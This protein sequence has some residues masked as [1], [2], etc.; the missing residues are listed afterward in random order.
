MASRTEA[1]SVECPTPFVDCDVDNEHRIVVVVVVAAGMAL[2]CQL[3]V[4]QQLV[5]VQVVAA[6]VVNN[7]AVNEMKNNKFK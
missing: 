2:L 6:T 1:W 7:V 3:P 5:V 4:E